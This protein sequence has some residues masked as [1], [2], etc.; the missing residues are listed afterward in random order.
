MLRPKYKDPEK[1]NT[2]VFFQYFQN[3][4]RAKEKSILRGS[5]LKT[6]RQ[7]QQVE[8]LKT[9]RQYECWKIKHRLHFPYPFVKKND[10]NTSI[11]KFMPVTDFLFSNPADRYYC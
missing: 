11:F 7:I 2:N 4:H 6:S 8:P 5:T 10:Q 9:S 1:Q 3:K